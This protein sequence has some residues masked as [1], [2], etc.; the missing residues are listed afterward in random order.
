[1]LDTMHFASEIR[2]AEG[3]PT[4]EPKTGKRELEMAQMLIKAMSDKFDPSKYEDT[5]TEALTELIEHKIEGVEPEAAPKAK[6][7]TNVIDI[8]EHLKRSLEEAERSKKK[9]SAA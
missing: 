4:G 8:M 2:A 5:Y 9:K 1:M 3:I 6:E 7:P